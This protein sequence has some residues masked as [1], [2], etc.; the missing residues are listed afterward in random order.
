VS[1][2]LFR[3]TYDERAGGP[4]FNYEHFT[5]R[6][7]TTDSLSE[8]QALLIGLQSN[9]ERYSNVKRYVAT[10]DWVEV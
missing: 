6:E 5:K 3:V 7:Q 2:T 9:V 4:P 1:T 8:L 10:F